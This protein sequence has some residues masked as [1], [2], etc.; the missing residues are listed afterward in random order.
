MPF[1]PKKNTKIAA[2]VKW[3][4]MPRKRESWTNKLMKKIFVK[5]RG[6]FKRLFGAQVTVEA[7]WLVAKASR[8]FRTGE[9]LG[10]AF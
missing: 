10:L 3:E 5:K 2:K 9:K 1:A 4:K 6:K 7:K 8:K